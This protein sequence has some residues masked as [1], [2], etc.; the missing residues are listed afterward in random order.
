M[1]FR[2][3]TRFVP[4]PPLPFPPPSSLLLPS[5][6]LFHASTPAPANPPPSLALRK[7][8]GAE[9]IAKIVD[10]PCLPESDGKFQISANG[11]TD[12]EAKADD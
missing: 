11:I 6:L 7:G 9:R 5:L 12:V 10:S 4:P 3:T 8:R 1:L 2:S